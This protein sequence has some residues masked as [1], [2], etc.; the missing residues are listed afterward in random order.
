MLPKVFDIPGSGLLADT[1]AL[2][3]IISGILKVF[4]VA[5]LHV[6]P[7]SRLCLDF[8]LPFILDLTLNERFKS[9]KPLT[10]PHVPY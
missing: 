2:L 6:F 3:G 10:E 8:S 1:D 4:I 7:S 9:Q 5:K